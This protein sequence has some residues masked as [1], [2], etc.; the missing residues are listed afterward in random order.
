VADFVAGISRLKGVRAHAGMKPLESSG[1]ATH[2]LPANA[3]TFKPDDNLSE[4]ITA[5]ID[6]EGPLRVA[7]DDGQ[8]IG[9]IDRA[10]ILKT[11]IEGTETS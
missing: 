2:D 5:A 11:V 4:L 6:Y 3:P 9:T 1:G 8:T 10:D 7:G